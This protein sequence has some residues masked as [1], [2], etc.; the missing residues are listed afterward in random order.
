[1]IGNAQLPVEDLIQLVES[2]PHFN[3]SFPQI[4]QMQ[5]LE[6]IL[7]IYGTQ[8]SERENCYIGKLNLQISYHAVRDFSQQP[9]PS[10]SQLDISQTMFNQ[11]NQ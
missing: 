1:M 9:Q 6:R 8:Y 5:K 3:E 10:E 11:A 7:M 2:Q 4:N